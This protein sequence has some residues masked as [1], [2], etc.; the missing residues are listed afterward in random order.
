M[1][2][3]QVA[4]Q[5]YEKALPEINAGKANGTDAYMSA[6]DVVYACARE[7]VHEEMDWDELRNS[8]LV[9]KFVDNPALYSQ[10]QQLNGQQTYD[11][12]SQSIDLF[13]GAL[14]RIALAAAQLVIADYKV[15]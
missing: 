5:V 8:Q 13:N 1:D 11:Q 10:L 3:E 15:K 9:L 12:Y 4:R 2:I 14:D 6:E 7:L